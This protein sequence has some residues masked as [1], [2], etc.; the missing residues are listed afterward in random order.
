MLGGE[1]LIDRCRQPGSVGFCSCLPLCAT[2]A[3][4]KWYFEQILKSLDRPSTT[5]QSENAEILP[6]TSNMVT[7]ST[8]H[9]RRD[10]FR[11]VTS[12]P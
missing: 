10:V 7:S 1:S 11:K 3:V 6:Q 9:G 4:S 5:L 12:P 8:I 2:T